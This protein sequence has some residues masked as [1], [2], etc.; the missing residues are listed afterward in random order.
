[1]NELAVGVETNT[2]LAN[3]K[4]LTLF[5]LEDVKFFEDKK[6]EI[7]KVFEK[8][9][10]WRT[11]VQ[12]RSII[13]DVQFPTVHGK[14]QQA[15]LEQKVQLDQT[16]ELG[17]MFEKTKLDQ[18]D[19]EYQIEELLEKYGLEQNEIAKKRIDIRI[20]KRK[21]DLQ[22]KTYE[23]EAQKT[24]CNYRMKEVKGWEKI[25]DDLKVIMESQGMSEEE[26]YNKET[27]EVVTTF[28]TY[29]NNFI[30]IAN[31]TN[32]AEINNLTSL[33][34]FAIQQAIDTGLIASLIPKCNEQQLDVLRKFGVTITENK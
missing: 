29:I 17:K 12:K 32:G 8:T 15:I 26:M 7:K 10:M 21:L 9:W 4:P 20:R 30:G 18:E 23:L 5:A 31:S 28:F 11:D 25:K 34:V 3:I 13:N 14:F 27:G 2:F 6:L 33:V 22:Y 24:A 1:M 19:L 16:L